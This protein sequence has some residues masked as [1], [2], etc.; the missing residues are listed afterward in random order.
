MKPLVVLAIGGN[1]LIKDP[2][3]VTVEDQISVCKETARHIVRIIKQGFRILITHGNGPQ[4][5][6]ILRRTELAKN[7]LHL[8]PLDSIVADTQGALGYILQMAISN[9][10][11]TQGIN[12]PIATIITQ[13]VVNKNDPSFQNPTKPIGSFMDETTALYHQKNDGW[14]VIEDAGRGYRRVVPS[15]HPIRI[16]ESDTIKTLLEKDHIIIA[17]G[18]GGIPVYENNG[19]ILK[20]IE[21]VI[22][23]DFASSLIARSIHADILLISTSVDHVYIN[24][25]TTEAQPLKNISIKDALE[26]IHQGQFGQGS[27]LPKIQASIEFVKQTKNRTI[28]SNTENLLEAINGKTGTHITI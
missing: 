28:I 10:L 3:R 2:S 24:H 7:E 8:V 1:S 26:Y 9:E 15:P 18:G 14:T 20:G 4:V 25:G 12:Y 23:K 19:G 5:G 27:M 16:V 11:R 22:D 21:A 17:V 13:V 6:F